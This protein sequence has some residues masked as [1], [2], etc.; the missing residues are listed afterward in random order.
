MI[1]ASDLGLGIMGAPREKSSSAKPSSMDFLLSGQ[2][3]RPA[4]AV[5]S[6]SR[7][8]TAT[9]S[10]LISASFS[11]AQMAI[12]LA[13]RKKYPVSRGLFLPAKRGGL[14]G[15]FNSFALSLSLC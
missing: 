9:T 6:E 11:R 15:G 7:N 10:E 13:F 1:Q 2:R 4:E 3:P 5:P 14:F 8:K 12:A